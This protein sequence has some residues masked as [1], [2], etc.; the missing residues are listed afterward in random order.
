MVK[1]YTQN[2]LKFI[3][4]SNDV[5]TITLCDLGASIYSIIFKNKE[6]LLTP[7]NVED[8]S[9]NN[10][11]HGKTIGRTANRIKGNIIKIDGKSYELEENE[12]GNTLHGGVNGLSTKTFKYK[13]KETNAFIKVSFNCSSKDGESGFPGKLKTTIT[14][15]IHKIKPEFKIGFKAKTDVPTL[16]DLTNHSYFNLGE[17]SVKPLSLKILSSKYLLTTTDELLPLSYKDVFEELDFRKFR[18]IKKGLQSPLIKQGKANGY[19][20]YLKFDENTKKPQITLKSKDVQLK[21]ST[22][23]EGVQIYTDNYEDDI[24]YVHTHEKLNRGIAIE[25]MDDY[26]NRKVLRP[27]EKY[28]RYIKY[29]F[30]SKHQK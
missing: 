8:Y 1:E 26:L 19:D 3:T 29:K 7:K 21:I 5:L 11:Y 25:P 6:M 14:Y 2:N 12:F 9:E 10:M 4:I 16:C 23:F 24:E 30:T 17:E 13:V 28:T 27:N 15:S 18:R 20:H 22:D